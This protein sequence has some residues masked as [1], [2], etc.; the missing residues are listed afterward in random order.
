MRFDSALRLASLGA[1]LFATPILA[2]E[3]TVPDHL[4][5]MVGD[6]R[7]E[8]EDQ[9][10]PIC[11]LKFT[12]DQLVGGWAIELPAPC[13]APFPLAASFAAWN[14]DE[15]NGTVLILDADRKIVLSLL[16][17]EDGLFATPEGQLPAFYLM[18]PYDEEG[19]GGEV[20]DVF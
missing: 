5:G 10:L 1:V 12:E 2:Q 20:G 17:G 8:Q 19:T 9:S 4:I 3:S 11:A 16:E 18:L 7:L 6:W 14:V 15:E 13:P